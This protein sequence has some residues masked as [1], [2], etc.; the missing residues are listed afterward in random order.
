MD[1]AQRDLLTLYSERRAFWAGRFLQ[2]DEKDRRLIDKSRRQ[3]AASR[4]LLVE[5]NGFHGPHR[6]I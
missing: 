1:E 3:L 4:S 6:K 5:T 2:L